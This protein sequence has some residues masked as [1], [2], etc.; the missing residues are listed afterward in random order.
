MISKAR[1][2]FNLAGQRFAFDIPHGAFA[3]VLG[4][5][6]AWYCWDAWHASSDVE[7]MILILPISIAAVVLY[8]FVLAGCVHRVGPDE[9]EVV[10]ADHMSPGGR[11]GLKIAGSMALL[12]GF[13]I[14]GPTIG[15]DVAS[16]VYMLLMMAFLGERRI[17]VLLIVPLVFS[18]TVIYCFGTLLATPLPVFIFRGQV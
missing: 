10:R 2:T 15:F 6:C 9:A 11:V 8:F 7:N 16:F 14:A 4:G 12:A 5:W 1:L 17:A 18:V 3:T 13:V